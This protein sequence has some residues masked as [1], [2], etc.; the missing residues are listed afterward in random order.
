MA[1]DEECRHCV[2]VMTVDGYDFG[3]VCVSLRGFLCFSLKCSANKKSE[4]PSVDDDGLCS[5]EVFNSQRA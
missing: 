2:E 3:A 4:F 5:V 1:K